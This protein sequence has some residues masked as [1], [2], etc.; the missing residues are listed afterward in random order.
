MNPHSVGVVVNKQVRNRI[1]SKRIH[2]RIE[3]IKKST[4]REGFLGR[5]R[6]ND[7]KKEEVNEGQKEEDFDEEGYAAAE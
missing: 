1:I 2:E 7:R 4:S 5:R 6:E 3:H